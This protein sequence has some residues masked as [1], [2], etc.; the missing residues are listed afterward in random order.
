MAGVFAR[1][2]RRSWFDMLGGSIL[3]LVWRLH[4][5]FWCSNEGDGV[6]GGWKALLWFGICFDGE[7]FQD[8]FGFWGDSGSASL[9]FVSLD[10]TTA[11]CQ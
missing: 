8:L 3:D 11:G 7:Y 6:S 9:M 2:D 4:S 1:F 10:G 5:P